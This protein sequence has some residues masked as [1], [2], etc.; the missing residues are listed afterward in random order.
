MPSSSRRADTAAP[1]ALVVG[2]I[3]TLSIALTISASGQPCSQPAMLPTW[4]GPVQHEAVAIP[5]A[6]LSW[7][8]KTGTTGHRIVHFLHG[9][10]G[11]SDSWNLLA[12]RTAFQGAP[13]YPA[14]QVVYLNPHSYLQNGSPVASAMDINAYLSS[15]G[16]AASAAQNIH[17]L[18]NFIVAH[19]YGGVLSLLLDSLYAHRFIF[20]RQ[21]GGIVAFG[22]AVNGA[23][24][25]KS[26]HPAGDNLAVPFVEHACRVLSNPRL[27]AP[28]FPAM[29]WIPGLDP[30][31]RDAVDQSCGLGSSFVPFALKKFNSP[32]MVDL[33][34]TAPLAIRLGKRV[35]SVPVV[36][37]YG[38][39]DEPV[40]WR[41]ATSMLATDS[42]GLALATDPFSMDG[43]GDLVTFASQQYDRH[44]SQRS[45][46][47]QRAFT[48]RVAAWALAPTAVGSLIAEWQ[49]VQAE[50][51][52][53][54]ADRAAR[55]YL[56]ANE[57]YKQ[58]IG[59]RTTQ[60]V[61]DGYWC[62][63]R[64]DVNDPSWTPV[65]S[66][67]DCATDEGCTVLPR[68]EHLAV[69]KPNDGVVL[70]ESA[71]VL[72]GAVASLLMPGT[73]HQQMRN[74]SVTKSV[75]NRLMN[76]QIPGGAYFATPVR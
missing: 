33:F 63:C 11:T 73:N 56:D 19:S 13:G 29:R 24:L 4:A 49:A 44:S 66:A 54:A 52:A 2:L 40:F 42:V 3:F 67:S 25:A 36:L 18:D 53:A 50:R 47:L 37:A 6:N 75:L 58:L 43:D 48:W 20:T 60:I 34:P 46:A 17:V 38:V 32:G 74:S 1:I 64:D 69:E 12:A 71:G 35:P 28:Q 72:N 21:F 59:A 55:W 9:L 45:D 16:A 76:G 8:G 41:T 30:L 23:Y 7:A 57:S 26:L 5:P 61:L 31:L 51:E 22:S 10:G 68:Y 39:E 65:A 70:A 15:T 14:R 62:R 27:W